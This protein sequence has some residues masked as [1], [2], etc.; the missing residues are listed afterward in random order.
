MATVTEVENKLNP[1]IISHTRSRFIAR[2]MLAVGTTPE[3]VRIMADRGRC[4][5]VKLH[6]LS[7]LE[8]NILK[9]ELLN[10]GGDLAVH[11]DIVT[12]R[13]DTTDAIALFTFEQWQRVA[14]V[15]EQQPWSL[16]L[17][18][19]VVSQ[20][21]E[22]F[23][24]RPNAIR[25]SSGKMLSI[26]PAP[27]IMGIVNVT[28]DSFYPKSRK[29][30]AAEAIQAGMQ[31]FHDGA[32]IVDVGGESTRPG[33]ESISEDEEIRRAIPVISEL[34]SHG[35]V[36]IDTTKSRVAKEALAAGATIINDISAG[37]FDS[38]I[39]KVAAESKCG[40]VL[41][42]MKGT[43]K[44]MQENPAY[45]NV[46]SEITA[47]LRA[48]VSVAISAG[49]SRESL[50]VDPG[51]GFGKLCEHNLEI[52]SRISDFRSLGLPILVG[53]SRKSFIG[54]CGG[55]DNPEDRLDGTTAAHT[56]CVLG[57]VS[58]LR[59]HDVKEARKALNVAREIAKCTS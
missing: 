38:G 42:H 23:E 25:L 46:I 19:R 17:I 43:P 9:Q 58:I 30:S 36:S 11:K 13:T 27:L 33:S 12:E 10:V 20:A 47:Y 32:A 28:P 48:R 18:S 1:I 55:G 41:M 45:D 39:F 6:N 53:L 51:I 35:I 57:G 26:S 22:R 16:P 34:S 31:M 15:L 59:V 4:Y 40:L 2:E 37:T 7:R 5:A 21:I 3:G 8:A 50:I 14:L 52:I 29:Q 24:T 44:T 49:I 56:A 54:K